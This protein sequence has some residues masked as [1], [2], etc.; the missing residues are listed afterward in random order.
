MK[1]QDK[2]KEALISELETLRKSCSLDLSKSEESYRDIIEAIGDGYYEIDLKGNNIFF[3]NSY[4]EIMGY[5]GK[6]LLSMN[7]RAYM[8]ESTAK[9]TFRVFNGVYR[10]GESVKIYDYEI[11]RK[12]GTKRTCSISVSLMKNDEGAPCGFR[13][14]VR[15]VTDL[16]SAEKALRESQDRLALALEG[17]EQGFWDWDLAKGK[18]IW[19]HR[20]LKMLGYSP[21]EIKADVRTFKG[22]IHPEDWPRVSKSLNDQ[23]GGHAPIYEAEYRARTK[24]GDW[25]WIATRGKVVERDPD[26]RPLRMLGTSLNIT[27]RKRAEQDKEGLQAQ[28]VQAQK[29]EAIGTLTSGI[30]HEFNNLLSIVSGYAELLLVDKGESDPELPDLEKIIQ[31]ARRGAEMVRNLLTFSQHSEMNTA[32]MDL[33]HEVEEVK[34]LLEPIFP[35]MIEIELC[36]YDGLKTIDADAVQIR[37][38]L[39]N[40]ALNARDA[41]AG[42]GKLTIQTN[43]VDFGSKPFSTPPVTDPANYVQLTV[44]DTGIGMDKETLDRIFDPFYSSKGLAYKTGLGLA[45]VHGIVERHRGHISCESLLGQ[46]TTFRI[47][48]PAAKAE[49][50]DEGSVK[51]EVSRG[52]ETILLV[53]DEEA[54]RDLASRI[55]NNAGYRVLTAGDGASAV[56]LYEKERENISLLILDLIM[57]KMG[58]KQCLERLRMIDSGVKVIIAS[59]YSDTES[60]EALIHAGAKGFVGKPFQ[61]AQLLRTVRDVLGSELTKNERAAC[62]RDAF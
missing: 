48:F 26:G 10:T 18:G 30:A 5:P 8:D 41:M 54:I 12:D 29:K 27:E 20:F 3:N 19:S 59:G 45:V 9:K 43:N 51:P 50:S 52:T 2:S 16:K 46:G 22:L 32:P 23:L 38:V 47:H 31:A 55:L 4:C 33:N 21:G 13:G 40:L 35:K 42:G 7:Y 1:D 6:E 39:V 24:S 44:S 28:L 62:G 61:G 60:G 53:D 36:L 25:I 57:P 56:E 17:A 15:D 49:E 11:I 37:Q 34:K 58:G 14:I